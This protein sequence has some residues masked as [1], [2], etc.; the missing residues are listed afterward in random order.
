MKSLHLSGKYSRKDLSNFLQ[1]IQQSVNAGYDIPPEVIK[2]VQLAHDRLLAESFSRKQDVKNNPS[3]KQLRTYWSAGFCPEHQ[4][5]K[6]Q[7]KPCGKGFFCP[8]CH[9]D[10]YFHK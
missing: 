4:N 1:I 5:K 9:D 6:L 10:I 2:T 7:L 8:A 3:K